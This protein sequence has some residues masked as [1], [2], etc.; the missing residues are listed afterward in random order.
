MRRLITLTFSLLIFTMTIGFSEETKPN[1]WSIG[2]GF[3]YTGFMAT[4]TDESSLNTFLKA[5]GYNPVENFRY[6]F[7]G[8][9]GSIISNFYIGGY[10]FGSIFSQPTDN[11]SGN[12][13]L[14]RET[15]GGGFEFGY[16]L[17]HLKN[18]ILLPTTSY[19]WRGTTY[20]IYN[21]TPTSTDFRTLLTNPSNM[22]IISNSQFS[23]NISLFNIIIFKGMGVYLKIGY[24]FTPTNAWALEG[25]SGHITNTPIVNPHSVFLSA[26]ALFGGVK[27][28]EE[29]NIKVE[30]NK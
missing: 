3:G 20:S 16:A 12:T 29:Y 1:K 6:S 27:A 11:T 28:M 25:Y 19:T 22:S 10:G 18:Y 2:G 5:N 15:G 24:S 7:G 14:K 8:G 17:L 30:K 26:G 9:G 4:Y 23:L 13:Y 21:T